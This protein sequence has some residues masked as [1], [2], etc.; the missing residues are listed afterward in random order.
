MDL[1]EAEVAERTLDDGWVIMV[2]PDL[3]SSYQAVTV[4]AFEEV[5]KDQGWEK[6]TLLD[7]DGYSVATKKAEAKADKAAAEAEAAKA[8][9]AEAEAPAE[10][11]AEGE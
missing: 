11:T 8:A 4:A 6:V 10:P 3:E 9:E 1:K 5:H 2:H 7:E